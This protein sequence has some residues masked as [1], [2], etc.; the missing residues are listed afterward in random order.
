MIFAIPA[1]YSRG[2]YLHFV[3]T[4]L[5]LLTRIAPFGA[6]MG[7]SRSVQ[8]GVAVQAS[9]YAAVSS[10]A[11]MVSPVA[12]AQT[13]QTIAP[14]VEDRSNATECL[15]LAIAYEAGYE[16]LEG[17]QAV[18][19]VV[20]N[21][22]RDPAFPKTVCGVVFAGSTRR[23]GCQ[24]TFTCDGSLYRHRIPENI[25]QAARQVANEALSGRAP[26]R[27]PGATHYHA[28]YVHPYW[29]SSLTRVTTIGAHIFYHAP[30][31]DSFGTPGALGNGIAANP[32]AP[33]GSS[34]VPVA[35]QA[36]A[37]WGLPMPTVK[38]LRQ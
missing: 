34:N 31:K 13:A 24:F 20:L 5:W 32:P 29:A 6:I 7:V 12:R 15:A 22:L 18:A 4:D 2:L 21:R 16:S 26:S 30:G 23:T 28:V 9:I 3:A 37:P 27:V 8:P 14:P 33:S 25:L 11:L 1:I 19:E 36:F 35:T 17:Q 38:T 10:I